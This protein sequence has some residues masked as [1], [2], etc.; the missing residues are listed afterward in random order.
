MKLHWAMSSIAVLAGV[1]CLLFLALAV[2]PYHS[3]YQSLL[4]G[5][6]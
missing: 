1:L 5:E 4:A 3:A 2:K 6:P